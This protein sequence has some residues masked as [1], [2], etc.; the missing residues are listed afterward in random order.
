MV[1]QVELDIEHNS[2]FKRRYFPLC[3]QGIMH[4]HVLSM[5]CKIKGFYAIIEL[6][7]C[8]AKF[9]LHRPRGD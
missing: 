8:I 5:P 3:L 6:N 2:K 1:H 4:E 9:K 7:S